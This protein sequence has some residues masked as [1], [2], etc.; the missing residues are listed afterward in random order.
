MISPSYTRDGWLNRALGVIGS[1]DSPVALFVGSAKPL[2]LV[3]QE[4]S[5]PILLQKFA[6]AAPAFLDRL[7][8]LYVGSDPLATAF[9]Q[10]PS[11][12]RNAGDMSHAPPGS[13]EP[14]TAI[15]LL[16][17]DVGARLAAPAD[18]RIAVLELGGGTVVGGRVVAQ[19]P[20]LASQQLYQGRDLAPTTD[21]H[22]ALKATL[23]DHLG[24]GLGDVDEMIFPDS[25]ATPPLP[26]L[27]RRPA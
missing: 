11:A 7:A 8:A 5:E 17:G 15:Q 23:I 25:D 20:G 10:G 9:A 4:T 1:A 27:F 22:A 2:I 26:D 3:G 13:V 24:L 6:P 21:L 19:W 18:M 12:R 16:A 14:G